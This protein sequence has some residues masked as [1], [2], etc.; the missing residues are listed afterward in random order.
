MR[1][2]DILLP[3]A[4][5]LLVLTVVVV[6]PRARDWWMDRP[7]LGGLP[8]TIEQSLRENPE[9]MEA[10]VWV[11]GVAGDPWYEWGA[12]TPRPAASAVKT[13]L[14]I[15]FFAKHAGQL[16]GPLPETAKMLDDDSHPAV[17]GLP[18]GEQDRIRSGLEGSTV[19]RLAEIMMGKVDTPNE[20]Y[21]AAANVIIAD[22]GGPD[23]ATEKIRN[24]M[25][26]FAGITIGRY[27]LA[28]RAPRDNE[29]TAAS[30]A[31]ALR[32]L[33]RRAVP[34]VDQKTIEAMREAVET[35]EDPLVG[36]CYRKDGDLYTD[37]LAVVRSGW[38]EN[39]R[40]IIVFVVM[41]MQPNPGSYTRELV[42]FRQNQTTEHLTRRVLEAAWTD[43]EMKTRPQ[44]TKKWKYNVTIDDPLR[45][46]RAR[47]SSCNWGHSLEF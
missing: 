24:R 18:I 13:A 25:P 16:D 44:Q 36:T 3:A 35:Q 27:M 19:R 17:V 23:G 31:A 9:G 39:A 29:A 15:E 4:I 6:V 7:G 12:S 41:T 33:A 14:L 30:L 1:K 21:N 46:G 45:R 28:A 22:L 40:G 37:P 8:L 26:E 32:C 5:A 2:R 47:E 43:L 34:G 38:C 10:S 42:C 11:G 20:V